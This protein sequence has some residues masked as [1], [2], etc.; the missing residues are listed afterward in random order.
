SGAGSKPAASGVRSKCRR[1]GR[2]GRQRR[3]AR[4]N[5]TKITSTRSGGIARYVSSASPL[6]PVALHLDGEAV[7][8][9]AG[10]TG[11]VR[12]VAVGAAQGLADRRLL[13]RPDEAV[14]LEVGGRVDPRDGL[15]RPLAHPLGEEVDVGGA[16]GRAE[17]DELARD[18]LEVGQV[19]RIVVV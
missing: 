2:R 17:I 9:E 1:R 12:L 14:E 16:A 15:D 4:E 8:G 6:E 10:E 19:A 3:S 13:G 7:A 18:V 5:G 11:G